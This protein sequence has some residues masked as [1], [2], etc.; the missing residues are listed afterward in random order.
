MFAR[1]LIIRGASSSEFFLHLL[2][3]A[4][5]DFLV[6]DVGLREEGN[7]LG[8]EGFS[9]LA[10]GNKRVFVALARNDRV[11]PRIRLRDNLILG[12]L[13]SKLRLKTLLRS[14]F[15][16]AR[17]GLGLMESQSFFI[18]T[19]SLGGFFVDILAQ[20]SENVSALRTIDV[21]SRVRRFVTRGS[22]SEHTLP[23]LEPGR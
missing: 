17:G 2:S 19:G 20:G 14:L 21:D 18:E 12:G 13:R 4:C 7:A 15:F 22:A 6:T 9:A 11:V 8:F 23:R 16:V 5:D 3:L 1:R 10:F